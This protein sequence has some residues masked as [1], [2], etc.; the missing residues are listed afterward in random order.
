[1]KNTLPPVIYLPGAGGE[2]PNLTGFRVGLS[3]ATRFEIL[4]YPGWQRSA[5][6]GFSAEV[7]IADLAAQITTK[8]PQG[9][10]RIVGFSMGAHLGYATALHLKAIGREIAGFCVIDTFMLKSSEP[11]A[12]NLWRKLKGRALLYS[13]TLLEGLELLRKRRIGEFIRFARSR[14]WRTL[15][16]LARGRLPNLLRR[17][18]SAGRLPSA[19]TFDPIFEEELSLRILVLKLTPWAASLDLEPVTLKVPTILIRSP[20]TAGDDAAWQRRCPNIQ[21]FEIAGEHSTLLEPDNIEILKET[22]IAA[23]TDW[24][25]G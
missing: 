11:L 14:L 7:L 5:A 21:I 9:K 19:L 20:L 15:F 10:I 23:T 2:A 16:G 18:A 12:G 6:N 22:F 3:D 1:M 25:E 13:R 24:C 8:V 4:T 17:F